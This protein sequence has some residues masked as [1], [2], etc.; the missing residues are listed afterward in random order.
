MNIDESDIFKLMDALLAAVRFFRARDEMNAE[1]H[2]AKSVRYSPITTIV[3]AAYDRLGMIA[4]EQ[5]PEDILIHAGFDLAQVTAWSR[6]L[7]AL[8]AAR[9]ES[10]T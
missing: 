5:M 8:A 1:V 4:S 10:E 6:K 2:L 3:E 7:A 9:R